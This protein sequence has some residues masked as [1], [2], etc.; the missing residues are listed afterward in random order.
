MSIASFPRGSR[1]VPSLPQEMLDYIVEHLRDDR[2]SLV[3]C[4]LAAR[5]FV[6]QVNPISSE[7]SVSLERAIKNIVTTN[8]SFGNTLT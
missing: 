2:Q 1:S 3:S 8:L 5:P 4:T 6:A 7:Y